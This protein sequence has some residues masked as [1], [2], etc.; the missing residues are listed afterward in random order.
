MAKYT[1][2]ASRDPFES[3]EATHYFQLAGDL[4]KA[5]NEVTLF[6]VQNGV[7]AV[8]KSSVSRTVA[9]LTATGV[10]VLADAFSLRGTPMASG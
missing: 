2:I 9:G 4:Q 3:T 6:L 7:F 5:G 10:A 1:L 8:R